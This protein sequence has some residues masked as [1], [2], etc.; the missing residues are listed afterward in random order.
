MIR[1]FK[2]TLHDNAKGDATIGVALYRDT[3]GNWHE[4]G[5][6]REYQTYPRMVRARVSAD[7][8]CK[9]YHKASC[10]KAGLWFAGENMTIEH[11]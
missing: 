11:A 5:R 4:I 2:T 1:Q 9:A 8:L 6:T 7:N 10:E 3:K